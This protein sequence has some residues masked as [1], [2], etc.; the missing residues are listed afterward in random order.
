[1]EEDREELARNAKNITVNIAK[2]VKRQAEN[3]AEMLFWCHQVQTIG[4]DLTSHNIY[5]YKILDECILA[6]A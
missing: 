1:M 5:L 3:A 6:I 4:D 2:A